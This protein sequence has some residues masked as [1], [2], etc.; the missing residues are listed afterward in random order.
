MPA[1]GDP[2]LEALWKN[3][4]DRWEEDS[5]H[6]AFLDH[7]QRTGHLAEAAARYRGM[8]GDR[9]RG[10]AAEKR[11]HGVATLAILALEASRSSPRESSQRARNLALIVLFLAGTLAWALYVSLR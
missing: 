11:L 8:T 5:A 9:T 7:C 4:L 3:V 6:A 1:R 10:P 2:A